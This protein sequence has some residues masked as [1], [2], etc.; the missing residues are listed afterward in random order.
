M[1]P[2]PL[3][4]HEILA[5]AAP[6]ARRGRHVDLPASDRMARRLRFKAVEPDDAELAARGLRE[7]LC[8]EQREDGRYQLTR[9]LDLPE[10][11][12]AG[13]QAELLALGEDPGALL[14][15]I[16][17][18]APS[19]QWRFGPG[20]VLAISRRLAPPAPDGTARAWITRLEAHLDT[21]AGTAA[22]RVKVPAVGGIPG[23]VEFDAAALPDD[24]LA[25]LGRP[26]SALWRA[27]AG[28]QGSLRL[29]RREPAR[30]ETALRLVLRAVEH[31]ALTLAEAPARYHARWAAARWGVV[32]RR[33]LPFLAM[34]L[35]ILAAWVVPRMTMAQD[36]VWRML[37][38]NAPPL[39]LGLGVCL[40]ELPRFDLPRWP[41]ASTAAAWALGPGA[42][43]AR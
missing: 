37:L 17:A 38:F 3:S 34:G 19:T 22:L 15:A 35:L 39:L 8:L 24:V 40:Q 25:V 33:S 6:F 26:W 36:S 28:W 20:F 2:Q 21:P 42:P 18:V 43:P 27:G 5:L 12:Q 11:A 32:L 23:D 1:Q 7:Q 31:L 16:D 9:L 29:P 41:R 30:S 4:H 14:A 13:L 10:G